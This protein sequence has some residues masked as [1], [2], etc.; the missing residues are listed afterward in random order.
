MAI[1]NTAIKGTITLGIG[2]MAD[3]GF[4]LLRNIIVARLVSPEDFGI[5]ALFIMTISFLEMVSNLA[6]DTL[7][8]QSPYGDSPRFQQTSQMMTAVRGLCIAIVVFCLAAP[9]AKI[10]NIPVATWA[11]RLLAIVPLIRGLAHQDMIRFQRQLNYKS[12]L[13]ADVISQLLSV[14]CA[15]PLSVWLGNYSAIL[16][17]IIIQVLVRTIVSHIMAKRSYTWGWEPLHAQQILA[18]GWP[19]LI[20]GILLFVIMQGDQFV[21]GAADNLFSQVTYSKTL[22]GFYSAS[23]VLTSAIVDAI[24][25][26]LSPL[27]F[28]LLSGVQDDNFQFHRRYRFCICLYASISGIL[29]IFFILMGSWLIVLVYGH[30]YAEASAVMICLGA[31]NSIRLLRSA[32]TTIALAKGDSRNP[33]ISNMFRALSFGM[34]FIFAASG[35][36]IVWIAAA[37]LIG[38]LLAIL[39]SILMLKYRLA[40]TIRPF[41]VPY[42]SSLAGIILA[43]LLWHFSLSSASASVLFFVAAALSIFMMGLFL[44]LFEEFFKEIKI[45]LKTFFPPQ[46]R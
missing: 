40:M 6:I 23:F 3:R 29:G 20:N 45:T 44:F 37:A 46:A 4:Q 32:A 24:L 39:P 28:P 38:E 27:M 19:L 5:A 12:L 34:A 10:F 21:I 17:L 7:L 43:A 30:Q 9:I 22:L 2:R 31:M 41:I 33:T 11:F 18:F 36:D 16:Y 25:S 13:M 8:V 35:L 14:L 42:I 26:V 1:R 15:W